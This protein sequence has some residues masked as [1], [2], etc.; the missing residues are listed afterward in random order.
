MHNIFLLLLLI[1]FFQGCNKKD[2]SK[3]IP[4]ENTIEFSNNKE[5]TPSTNHRFKIPN[6]TVTKIPQEKKEPSSP[7]ASNTF[8]LKNLKNTTYTAT[9]SNQ[10]ITFKEKTKKI[11]LIS[12]FASW[13]PPCIHQ[14]PYFNDLEKKYAQDVSLIAVL[15]HD[16]IST[17]QL[18]SFLSKNSIDYYLSISRQ[19]DDFANLVAKTLDLPTHFS[20]PLTVMY[21][22]GKYFTHYEGIVPIEMIEYDIA[23]AKEQSK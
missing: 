18:T 13:C 17:S 8:I 1:L 4:V 21:L 6:H 9:L 12:F 3:E 7:V 5:H 19:N 23:Q 15:T 2:N 10:T 11:V 20:I 16:K 22:N 14:I